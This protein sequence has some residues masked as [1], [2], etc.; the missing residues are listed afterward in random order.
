MSRSQKKKKPDLEHDLGTY[1][2]EGAADTAGHLSWRDYDPETSLSDWTIVVEVDASEGA[3]GDKRPRPAETTYHVHRSHLGAGV[4]Q[5]QYFAA[6]FRPGGFSEATRDQTSRLSLK[7]SQAAAF[8]VC[9]DF[10]YNGELDANTE[11]A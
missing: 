6:L 10:A 5:S 3:V 2:G 1:D 11:N 8:G 4:R 9:L 7:P